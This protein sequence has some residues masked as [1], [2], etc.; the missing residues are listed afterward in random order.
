M[1]GQARLYVFNVNVF[2][3]WQNFAIY[4]TDLILEG[5]IFQRLGAS[6]AKSL[7]ESPN[8]S[9]DFEDKNEIRTR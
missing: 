6:I 3:L 7:P 5:S 9:I 2:K 8:I 1:G 4:L